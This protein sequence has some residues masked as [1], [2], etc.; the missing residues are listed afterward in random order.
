MKGRKPSRTHSSSRTSQFTTLNRAHGELTITQC[1]EDQN[2]RSPSPPSPASQS[3]I[4]RSVSRT[5]MGDPSGNLPPARTGPGAESE[6]PP[7]PLSEGFPFRFPFRGMP[8]LAPHVQRKEAASSP[9]TPAPSSFSSP[10]EPL[11]G[12]FPAAPKQE[13][14]PGFPAGGAAKG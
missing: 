6:G 12:T 3:T 2:C 13:S 10:G 8:V 1:P 4:Q 11:L 7:Q 9:P 14:P 5:R